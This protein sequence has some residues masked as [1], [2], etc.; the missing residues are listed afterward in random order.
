M[1]VVGG[2]KVSSS[3]SAGE[4]GDTRARAHRE[5]E[6]GQQDSKTDRKKDPHRDGDSTNVPRSARQKVNTNH[7]S[8]LLKSYN[9]SR[10]RL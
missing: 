9:S 7:N 8:G 2:E 5:R 3:R 6:R 4:K 1:G 10:V